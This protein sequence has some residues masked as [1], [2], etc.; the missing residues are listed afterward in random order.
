MENWINIEGEEISLLKNTPSLLRELNLMP[1]F[2]RRFFEFKYT[3]NIIPTEDEQIVFQKDFLKERGFQMIN[4]EK[5]GYQT[6]INQNQ[7]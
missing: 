4:F 5:F 1:I 2:L 3:K 6:I 7:K